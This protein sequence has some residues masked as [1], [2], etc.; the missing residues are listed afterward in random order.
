MGRGRG[1]KSTIDLG[2]RGTGTVLG[3]GRATVS[4]RRKSS[5]LG[6]A[7]VK[8]GGTEYKKKPHEI[9]GSKGELEN[10]GVQVRDGG[11]ESP[12]DNLTG[13]FLL[14]R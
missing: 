6:W 2:G 8:E 7:G 12:V 14:R 13:R 10:R 1:V 11:T 5:L 4:G 3:S 9:A